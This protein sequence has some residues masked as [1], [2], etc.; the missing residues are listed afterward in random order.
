MSVDGWTPPPISSASASTSSGPFNAVE[1]PRKLH[2]RHEA[3]DEHPY[4]SDN[5]DD[6]VPTAAAV[7]ATDA[8][9]RKVESSSSD[10]SDDDDDEADESAPC[11]A[12]SLELTPEAPLTSGQEAAE[13]KLD[14]AERK[15]AKKGMK[16]ENEQTPAKDLVAASYHSYHPVLQ[17]PIK[18]EEKDVK[19][20]EML[21][22]P[23]LVL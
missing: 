12:K 16:D 6:T 20:R 18:E 4:H 14:T 7:G 23:C 1:P 17:E 21:G 9:E 10:S 19:S 22:N 15:A 11:V 5:P 13:V 3:G 2:C 8:E